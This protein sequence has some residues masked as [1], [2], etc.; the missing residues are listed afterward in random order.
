MAKKKLKSGISNSRNEVSRKSKKSVKKKPVKPAIS[1][2][3]IIGL[4]EPI[5][6]IGEKK[7]R[8]V[9]KIDTGATTSSVDL[10]LAASLKLGPVVKTRLVKSA[11]GSRVRP[12]ISAD[13]IFAKKTIKVHFTIADRAHM[14]YR[15]LIGKNILKKGFLIDPSKD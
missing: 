1:K 11:S 13:V 5:T 9:A 7:K 8:V 10:E 15:V 4:T 6:L 12:I 14:K 3:I 2:K